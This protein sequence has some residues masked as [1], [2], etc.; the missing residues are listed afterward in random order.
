MYIFCGKIFT[1]F[2]CLILIRLFLLLSCRCSLYIL[3]IN[4]YHELQ[5]FLKVFMLSFHFI[6]FSHSSGRWAIQGQGTSR[7]GVWESTSW[8]T[9]GP[10]L[11]VFSH[12]RKLKTR[13]SAHVS[14]CKGV[15]LVHEA[16]LLWPN[17]S[18]NTHFLIWLHWG[19][20]F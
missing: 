16:P 13:T 14:S 12:S 20:G 11:T 8:F 9:D 3:V 5:I 10:F 7:S 18:P 6:N 19:L 1:H 4:F 17:Y 15:N 2:L